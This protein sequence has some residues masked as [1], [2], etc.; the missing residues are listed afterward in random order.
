MQFSGLVGLH[1]QVE[2]VLSAR[3]PQFP[4]QYPNQMFATH[5]VGAMAE[6][7]VAKELGLEWEAHINHFS[8][9]DLVARKGSKNIWIEVRYTPKRVDIKVKDSDPDHAIVVGVTGAPPDFK[10]LGFVKA[11]TVKAEA[12]QSSPAPGKPAWFAKEY[13]SIEDLKKWLKS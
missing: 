6:L 9:P 4:E 2:S 13:N 10:M 11:G 3:T 5:V 12:E 1:R 8:L 7:A